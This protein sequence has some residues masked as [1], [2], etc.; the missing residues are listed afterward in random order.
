[1]SGLRGLLTASD[2]YIWQSMNLL[3]ADFEKKT[4]IE[5]VRIALRSSLILINDE[6][7]AMPEH[8]PW[9]FPDPAE[10]TQTD[11]EDRWTIV[12]RWIKANKRLAPI[13]P[14]GGFLIDGYQ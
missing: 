14:Y 6:T 5:G 8:F 10:A 2:L 12:A 7:V 3:H 13:Y 1:M 4:G 9:I 11:I